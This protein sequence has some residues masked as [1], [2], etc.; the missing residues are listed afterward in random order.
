MIVCT[1]L[2]GCCKLGNMAV[3]GMIEWYGGWK[4]F[5]MYRE[6]YQSK[7][8]ERWIAKMQSQVQKQ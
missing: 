7:E 1:M 8:R 5:L 2:I 6:W 4:T 3:R